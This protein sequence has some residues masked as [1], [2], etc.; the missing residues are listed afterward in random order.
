MEWNTA[1]P[2]DEAFLEL[3]S[4]VDQMNDPDVTYELIAMWNMLYE[5][6]SPTGFGGCSGV[7]AA[8]PNGT[9]VHG[10]NMDYRFSFQGP[11]A[12]TY[13]W[14]N[15]T[16]NAV[17][18]R[19][20]KPIM[21][22]TNWPLHTFSA[23]FMRYGNETGKGWTYEQN[24]RPGNDAAANLNAL[25]QG[26]KVWGDIVRRLMLQTADF[27]TAVNT[28]AT[29]RFICPMYFIMAGGGPYEG[30][31]ISVDRMEHQL[32]TPGLQL[33]N[34][35]NWNQVQTND[36]TNKDPID[37]RRP[38]IVAEL[39]GVSQGDVGGALVSSIM[40]SAPA[41]WWATA[42]SCVWIPATGFYETLLY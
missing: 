41:R 18:M 27:T 28:L 2:G 40:D 17:W 23:T 39:E 3:Q 35:T 7:L 15:I 13:N 4:M 11:G 36:D 25:K 9:V 42:Y 30:A 32:D 5:L 34:E 8:M 26:G 33:L 1:T 24:T 21:K 10:R 14:P 38:G 29:T 20:G 19:G 22:S 16:Y 6:A 37:A 12:I 31:V